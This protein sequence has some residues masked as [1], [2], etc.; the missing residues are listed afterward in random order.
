M[1]ILLEGENQY[2]LCDHRSLVDVA[3]FPFIR[4]CANVDLNWL[5]TSYPHLSNWL[6]HFIE[7]TLFSSVMDKYHEYQK[8]QQPLIISF[9][10]QQTITS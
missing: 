4:Q 2:I 6:N 10:E 3:V 8:S 9:H 7:A 5:D 1:N